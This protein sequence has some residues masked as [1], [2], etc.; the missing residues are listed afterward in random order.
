MSAFLFHPAAFL[1]VNLLVIKAKTESSIVMRKAAG[2][3]S[4]LPTVPRAKASLLDKLSGLKHGSL[5]FTNRDI[6]HLKQILHRKELC[7]G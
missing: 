7:L 6:F 1:S 3:A 5:L 4:L 2:W